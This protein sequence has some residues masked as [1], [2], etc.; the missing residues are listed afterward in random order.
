MLYYLKVQPM[1]I[2]APSHITVDDKGVA[3]IEGTRIK[4]LHIAKERKGRGS[5][6]EQ[7]HEAFPHLTLA[8]VHAALAYYY[9]HQADLDAQIERDRDE[10]EKLL[11]KA[12]DEGSP[13]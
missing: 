9:D 8:Q 5:S 6:P 2:M 3:R 11:T 7:I 1:S 10:A 12:R 13:V 4:V